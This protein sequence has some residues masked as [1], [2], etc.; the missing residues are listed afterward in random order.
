M[1]FGPLINVVRDLPAS[2][3]TAVLVGHN[4]DLQDLT[5]LLGDH[6]AEFKTSTIAV[7]RSERPWTEAGH[8]WAQLTTLITPR[9]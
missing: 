3:T 1:Y 9:G 2:I 8:Q 4:P 7:L 6:P 5:A